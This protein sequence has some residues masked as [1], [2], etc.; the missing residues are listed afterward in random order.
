MSTVVQT[1]RPS[2]VADILDICIPIG[3][4]VFLS[5]K[6]GTAKCLGRDTPVLMYDGW[7]KMVQDVEV[8]DLVMGPDSQPR[9]VL[10]TTAG[11]GPL[12]RVSPVKGD[13]YVVNE[14]HILS[15]RESGE[16]RDSYVNISV[17]DYLALPEYRRVRLKGYRVGVDFPNTGPELPIPPYILGVWLG[18]G[19]SATSRFTINDL[20]REIVRELE[21][22][23][24]GAGLAIRTEPLWN[25]TGCHTYRIN[26]TTRKDG[27]NAFLKALRHLCLLR[28]KHIPDAYLLASRRDRLELLAGLLDTDGSLD[29]GG[30]A[31][32]TKYPHI[33]EGIC[34]LARSVGLAAYLNV[35]VNVCTNTG[36][37]GLYGRVRI[38]GDVDM[39]PLRCP[40]K[41]AAPRRQIK[42]VLVTGIEV[43]AIGDGEYFGF[44]LDGDH[45]FLLG[46]FTVTHN[47]ALVKQ[48]TQRLGYR[49][50]DHR[51]AQ[52]DP[53]DLRGVPSVVNGH[54]HFNPPDCFPFAHTVGDEKIVLFFDE[55]T[56]S[57]VAVQNAAL[58][59]LLDHSLGG[60][61]LGPNV[62]VIGAGNRVEDRA[63][64]NKMTTAA[65]SRF[66][67]HLDVDVNEEDWQAWASEAGI[68]PMVRSFI[69]AQPQHL[70]MFD[71]SESPRSFPCPR[72]WE[73]VSILARQ[74][75][76]PALGLVMYR[77]AVGPAAAASFIKHQEICSD[78]PNPED[79]LKDPKRAPVPDKPPVMY[80]LT[81]GLVEVMRQNHAPKRIDALFTYL[82][83]I[84]TEYAIL[85]VMDLMH[86][87]VEKLLE[88][89]A[90]VR[91]AGKHRNV[92]MRG[93]RR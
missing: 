21:H 47:S 35:S 68:H 12:Y 48:A 53:V 93:A 9:T 81:A 39:I 16:P 78:L 59:P 79:V 17:R 83:R 58:E 11:V 22:Y 63:G 14:D 77:G 8:G 73:H 26:G 86:A 67:T 30:Y 66:I 80:G 69:R 56:Q 29:N 88:H 76:S 38:T 60:I 5:G 54:T 64:A 62:V 82:D 70:C 46:D 71:P 89:E 37:S 75:P 55:F 84:K 33:A 85:T 49:L 41:Q 61:P 3:K 19:A 74:N 92:I 32:A 90:G 40:R 15:L 44:S 57:P 91:F 50:I 7:T 23:A 24:E 6:P 4:P 52:M 87:N 43:D 18:D 42:D 36:A 51:L 20:D 28:N 25:K 1:V 10:D 13:P 72:T 45:R 31:I 2:Q 65:A 27:A 34:F